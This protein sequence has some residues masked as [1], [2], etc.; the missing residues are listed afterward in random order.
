MLREKNRWH[1]TTQRT[2]S[3]SDHDNDYAATPSNNQSPQTS[4][5]NFI[6][7]TDYSI[8]KDRGRA[9]C[10]IRFS[11]KTDVVLRVR[12]APRKIK[13]DAMTEA[14]PADQSTRFLRSR[15]VTYSSIQSARK[16]K[17]SEIIAV[18]D[19]GRQLFPDRD[20]AGGQRHHHQDRSNSHHQDRAASDGQQRSQPNG[21]TPTHAKCTSPRS[22]ALF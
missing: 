16:R 22:V 18:A 5:I 6:D 4:T 10:S 19:D 15:Q 21:A 14:G 12:Q 13:A 7:P 8:G 3:L 2:T 1:F 20:D 9:F 17:L 11:Q